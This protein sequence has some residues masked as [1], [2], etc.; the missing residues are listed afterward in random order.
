MKATMRLTSI[1]YFQIEIEALQSKLNL[2][3]PNQQLAEIE[4]L[5]FGLII[6]E[7]EFGIVFRNIALEKIFIRFEET[8]KYS[9]GTLKIIL[10]VLEKKLAQEKIINSK[11][12]ERN[13]IFR[14]IDV[15][16][17]RIHQINAIRRFER[18][19]GERPKKFFAFLPPKR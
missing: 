17:R 12:S 3:L 11:K 18:Y 13:I 10:R 4:N 1:E 16:E 14:G 5:P 15:I 19:Y 8:E 2:K 9:D 6:E 7:P